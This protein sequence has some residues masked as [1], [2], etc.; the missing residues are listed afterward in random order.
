MPL[1]EVDD[2]VNGL[3]RARAMEVREN[4]VPR[5]FVGGFEFARP[6]DNHIVA[7]EY[8]GFL[9][10][11]PETEVG[12]IAYEEVEGLVTSAGTV[13]ADLLLVAIF[14]VAHSGLED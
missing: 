13:E 1:I 4:V 8:S 10:S 3:G 12:F 9:A 14:Q 2:E 5:V 11:H 6:A 7:A